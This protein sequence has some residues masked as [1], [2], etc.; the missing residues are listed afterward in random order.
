[1]FSNSYEQVCYGVIYRYVMEK[2]VNKQ[3][4]LKEHSKK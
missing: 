2:F 4:Q 1:M 3:K